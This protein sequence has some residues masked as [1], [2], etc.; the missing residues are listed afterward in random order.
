MSRRHLPQEDVQGDPYQ[1]LIAAIVARAV[2][3]A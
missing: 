2:A 1:A 3:D